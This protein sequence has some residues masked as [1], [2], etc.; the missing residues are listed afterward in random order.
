MLIA[1]STLGI[2]KELRLPACPTGQKRSQPSTGD[3][4][5]RAEVTTL[6][7]FICFFWFIRVRQLIFCTSVFFSKRPTSRCQGNWIQRRWRWWTNLAAVWKILSTTSLSNIGL[8]VGSFVTQPAITAQC[9]VNI[10]PAVTE[11]AT[12][13]RRCWRIASTTT[14][15]IWVRE[16]PARPSRVPSSTGATC[17]LWGSESCIKDEQ[18]SRSPSTEETSPARCP[19]MGEVRDKHGHCEPRKLVFNCFKGKVKTS[20]WFLSNSYKEFVPYPL[21]HQP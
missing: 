5:R 8:W 7:S 16:K 17:H 11:Q 20:E 4:H 12:G 21:W 13:G 9:A 2:S 19:S 1:A 10:T 18:T 15:L 6:N 3:I 14:H